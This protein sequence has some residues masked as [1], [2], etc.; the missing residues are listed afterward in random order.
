MVQK[1]TYSELVSIFKKHNKEHDIRCGGRGKSEDA[2]EGV[3]VYSPENWDEPY[4]L[5]ARSYEVSSYNKAFMDGCAGY[6]IFGCS[7]DGTD[8]CVRLE[9]IGWKVDYCYLKGE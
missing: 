2:I 7:L 4:S 8:V 5:E 1:L 6:S 9:H 3:I